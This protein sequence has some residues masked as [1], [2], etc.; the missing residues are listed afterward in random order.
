MCRL[1][2][3][4][5]ASLSWCPFDSRAEQRTYSGDEQE[6]AHGLTCT[7]RASSWPHRRWGALH[8]LR[9]RAARKLTSKQFT[10]GL[11]VP[12]QGGPP[13]RSQVAVTIPSR[14]P[15]PRA[16]VDHRRRR[17]PSSAPA[18]AVTWVCSAPAVSPSVQ[19]EGRL[20]GRAQRRA[21]AVHTALQA[22]HLGGQARGLGFSQRGGAGGGR[23]VGSQLVLARLQRL[24]GAHGGIRRLREVGDR[25]RVA[26]G[27]WPWAQGSGLA[28][29]G[30]WR[31]QECA[32]LQSQQVVGTGGI[33]PSPTSPP[34]LS[35][36]HSSADSAA[37][38]SAAA[39]R[40]SAAPRP[41]PATDVSRSRTRR[42]RT[43][44]DTAWGMG[45]VGTRRAPVGCLQAAAVCAEGAYSWPSSPTPHRLSQTPSNPPTASPRSG[46]SAQAGRGAA[47]WRGWP[48]R[49]AAPPA[50]RWNGTAPQLAGGRVGG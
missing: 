5:A 11:Q 44:A 34:T 16:P 50:Q 38:V 35:R 23:H 43:W 32:G 27:E 26:G 33:Q 14:Q 4:C 7:D 45:V 49:R 9:E 18:P 6:R 30:L 21:G 46:R 8:A 25:R 31:C 1:P 12:R 40:P 20:A 10:Q 42:S 24:D 17:P 39:A 22:R 29:Q 48:P 41:R 47:R 13:P 37:R 15:H 3:G 28:V 2:P 19:P 36:R